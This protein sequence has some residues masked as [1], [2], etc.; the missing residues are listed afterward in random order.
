MRLLDKVQV[1]TKEE[2]WA[3]SYTVTV[4]VPMQLISGQ[5]DL[6]R[7]LRECRPHQM[8][9]WLAAMIEKETSSGGD[10]QADGQIQEGPSE[11]VERQKI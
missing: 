3:D 9:R 2:P 4:W 5:P 1:S 10:H 6:L 11:A 7:C 8:L